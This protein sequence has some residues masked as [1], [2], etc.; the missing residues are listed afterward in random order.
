MDAILYIVQI[1]FQNIQISFYKKFIIL[2]IYFNIY[3]NLECLFQH[4][5]QRQHS[6]LQSVVVAVLSVL[7]MPSHSLSGC[8]SGVFY[9]YVSTFW[10]NIW[11]PTLSYQFFISRMFSITSRLSSGLHQC[12][13]H[14]GLWTTRNK[15][16]IQYPIPTSVKFP[17]DKSLWLLYK[18]ACISSNES[19]FLSWS[20]N[21]GSLLLNK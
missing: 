8:Q 10:S 7:P 6:L 12:G 5:C 21:I 15:D 20:S 9:K 16:H 18:T 14:P 2:I 19:W 4:Q 13:V 11:K 3:Q 1:T 17:S